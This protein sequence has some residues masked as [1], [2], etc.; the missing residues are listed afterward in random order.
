VTEEDE[1]DDDGHL[2][3]TSLRQ[4][5]GK[6]R[7]LLKESMKK[8]DERDEDP[9]ATVIG[10]TVLF[11]TVFLLLSVLYYLFSSTSTISKDEMM[12]E[13]ER[14]M[15]ILLEK[16]FPSQDQTTRRMLHLI[17]RD[18]SNTSLTEPVVVLF[19]GRQ[20]EVE[21]FAHSFTN[22]WNGILNR[23]RIMAIDTTGMDKRKLESQ[24]RDR[25]TIPSNGA[26]AVAEL[27]AIDALIEDAPLILH[28]YAD[29]SS[30]PVRPALIV[31]SVA[32]NLAMRGE[33]CDEMLNDLLVKSW[34]N[35]KLSNDKIYPIL[36]RITSRVI[37]L[38]P[39]KK[40]QSRL[41]QHE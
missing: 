35:E 25:L 27:R 19:V 12:R 41:C 13:Y 30:A 33:R 9:N 24:L 32:S 10:Y 17:G 15:R 36:S 18:I 16:E 37:C 5:Q 29:H 38:A 39:E 3:T 20:S 6:K 21:C 34:T 2:P 14:E 40:T 31:L 11:I 7:P 26:G 22:I 8:D 1:Q 23:P 4:R 28:A